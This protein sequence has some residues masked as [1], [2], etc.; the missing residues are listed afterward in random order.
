MVSGDVVP[1]DHEHFL[2]GVLIQQAAA[3]LANARLHARE[4]D[5]AERLRETNLALERSTDEAERAAAVARRS[6]AV[7]DRLTRVAT[8]GEGPQGIALS[9]CTSSPAALSSSRTATATNWPRPGPRLPIARSKR[10][11]PSGS[12]CCDDS[13]QPADR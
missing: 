7:H 2:V 4:R 10:R 9:P 11:P 3:A 1:E 6:L 5:H 13:P 8:A 12:A